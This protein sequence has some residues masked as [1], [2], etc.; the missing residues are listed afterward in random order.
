MTNTNLN[1]N[2]VNELDHLVKANDMDKFVELKG[3]EILK[4]RLSGNTFGV[5]SNYSWN[6]IRGMYQLTEKQ[7]RKVRSSKGYHRCLDK[8]C[9]EKVDQWRTNFAK[10]NDN[11]RTL[12][13]ST[14][15][16]ERIIK[17]SGA[18]GFVEP[19]YQ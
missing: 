11:Y 10:D 16:N 6:D 19:E 15:F 3:D 13:P 5:R 2:F 4:N 14:Y 12:R 1:A 8:E 7:L 17:L 18:I 9:Q